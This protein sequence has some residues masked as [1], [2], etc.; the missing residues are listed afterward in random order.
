MKKVRRREFLSVIGAGAISLAMPAG[1]L[2][3]ARGKKSGRRPNVIFIITDDQSLDSF[4]FI[5]NKALTPNIDR[6]AAEGVYFSRAY[7]SSSVCT[8]S[9]Y[10]CLTGRYASRSRDES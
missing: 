2:A 4:G 5:R 8:P 3:A 7:A 10:T 1:L 6:L 9:R